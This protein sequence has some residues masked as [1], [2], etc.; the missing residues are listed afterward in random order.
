[1]EGEN[2]E[3]VLRCAVSLSGDSD[4]LTAI[5]AS[6]AEGFYGI[7]DE[8]NKM[9]LPKLSDFLLNAL[10]KWEAWRTNA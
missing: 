10:N 4:T 5:A 2:F 1:M 8:I 3:D 6:I 7:P 9:I